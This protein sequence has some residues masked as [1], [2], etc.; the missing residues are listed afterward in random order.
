MSCNDFGLDYLSLLLEQ[1]VFGDFLKTL[2]H[3]NQFSMQFVDLAL[4][5]Q[6]QKMSFVV[7]VEIDGDWLRRAISGEEAHI[8][9]NITALL[10]FIAG[11]S[12]HDGGIFVGCN[13]SYLSFMW[14]FTGDFVEE[15]D[16]FSWL[17]FDVEAKGLVA[18]AKVESSDWV[19]DQRCHDD[20]F[21]W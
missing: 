20:G 12:E 10:S 9:R 8:E 19:N 5:G 4:F 16:S 7:S 18:D 1:L 2:P 21:H 6:L 11:S 13:D 17:F 14:R 15:F 3:I